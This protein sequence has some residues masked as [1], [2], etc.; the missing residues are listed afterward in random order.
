MSGDRGRL[1]PVDL[2]ADMLRERILDLCQGPWA[3]QRGS[4]DGR[5]FIAL[6]PL[7]H[8]RN[9][10]SFRVCLDGPYKGM[11]KDFAT[12][13]TW[14][15]LQFT[16]AL[17]CGGETGR[18]LRWS[19]AWLGID[20][21][22]PA[23]LATARAVPAGEKDKLDA[24]AAAKDERKRKAA[25]ALWLSGNDIKGS[26]AESYLAGRGIDL[27]RFDYPL[28]SLKFH[29]Q[30]WCREADGPLPAMLAAVVRHDGVFAAVHRTYLERVAGRGWRK[31]PLERAKMALGRY[32][33][34]SIRLWA[35]L[36]VDPK[37]G[38]V[39]KG[40]RLNDE[41]PGT[42]EIHV[43]EGIE[44][45]LSVALSC[46]DFR[47][48]AGISVS[49]LGNLRFPPSVG[50]VVLW[51]DNDPPGSQAAAGFERA[52]AELGARHAV[53]IATVPVEFKDMNDWLQAQSLRQEGSLAH[54]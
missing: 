38:E 42:V 29:P 3:L 10:G 24:E 48:A 54:G 7:R 40:R 28:G 1:V 50:R 19:R 15:P 31:A 51:R 17:L 16:A 22:D 34:A 9:P 14:S 44:N 43:C 2:V 13:E 27:S 4:V 30:V 52:A 6:N 47:V 12:G 8:D 25:Y 18:A 41:K 39:K 32:A 46:P 5:E 33:G 45:A 53:A 26:P 20:D 35:G 36:R 49:N 11:V 21:V 37:T 23:R